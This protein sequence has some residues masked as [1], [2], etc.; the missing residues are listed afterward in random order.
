MQQALRPEQEV[1]V[2]VVQQQV[3]GEEVEEGLK[4]EVLEL[5]EQSLLGEMVVGEVLLVGFQEPGNLVRLVLVGPQE[6][7]N[8]AKEEQLV[9]QLQANLEAL[10]QW[11]PAPL[12]HQLLVMEVVQECPRFQVQAFDFVVLKQCQQIHLHR[13]PGTIAVV[14]VAYKIQLMEL[15]VVVVLDELDNLTGNH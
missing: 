11:M 2:A 15:V 5:V 9:Q 6:P 10:G 7:G 13:I 14:L 12:V 1:Q 3:V 4:M 8:L